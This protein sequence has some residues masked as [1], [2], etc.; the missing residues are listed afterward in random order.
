[1]SS[2]VFTEN[3]AVIEFADGSTPISVAT[4]EYFFDPE[5]GSPLQPYYEPA[6]GFNMTDGGIY[7]NRGTVFIPLGQISRITVS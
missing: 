7:L 2:F 3:D 1:M 6:T 5:D 4:T